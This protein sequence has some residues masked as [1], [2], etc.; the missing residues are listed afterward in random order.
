M[1]AERTEDGQPTEKG[2]LQ[3]KAASIIASTLY[4]YDNGNSYAI[5]ALVLKDEKGKFGPSD[6][7]L[8]IGLDREART[9]HSALSKS[10]EIVTKSIS[11]DI[12]DPSSK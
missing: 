1:I 3:I 4:D 7:K 11:G 6:M 12:K 9:I 8:K 10:E 5:A 2:N